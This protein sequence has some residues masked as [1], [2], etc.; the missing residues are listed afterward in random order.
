MGV[1]ES[2]R[3]QVGFCNVTLC[4]ASLCFVLVESIEQVTLVVIKE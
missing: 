2:N 1:R 3:M 4:E